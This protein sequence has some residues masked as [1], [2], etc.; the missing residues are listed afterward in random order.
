MYAP[1]VA[2]AQPWAGISERFQRYG[3][4]IPDFT[5]KNDFDFTLD[6]SALHLGEPHTIYRRGHHSNDPTTLYIHYPL[7]NDFAPVISFVGPV[8]DN[9]VVY[10]RIT[11]PAIPETISRALRMPLRR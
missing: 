5:L 7:H 9:G 2:R 11:L 6:C 4:S 3:N 10:P 8:D 1:R